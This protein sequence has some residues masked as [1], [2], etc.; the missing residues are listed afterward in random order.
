MSVTMEPKIADADGFRARRRAL[1]ILIVAVTIVAFGV[2]TL[3]IA[4]GGRPDPLDLRASAPLLGNG[5]RFHVGDDPRWAAADFDDSGW[6][7][8]DLSAP[9]S[10]NDGD[11]GLPNYTRGWWARGH[12]GHTGYGWYRRRVEVSAGARSWDI[13]GPTA[14]EDGYELYWN[15][16]RLG[17]SGRLDPPQRMV[18]T[19]PMIFPLPEDAAGHSGVLAIR[20]YMLPAGGGSNSGGIHVAPTLAPRP[21]SVALFHVEWWRTIAGY[22]VEVVEPL[23]MLGVIVLALAT[24]RHSMRPAFTWMICVALAFSGMRRLENAIVSWTDLMSLTTYVWMAGVLA[25]LILAAWAFAW[26]RWCSKPLRVIDAA[27]VVLLGIA[28]AGIAMKVDKIESACR[29]A[30]LLLFAV[31]AFRIIR[32]SPMR[33]K[34]FVTMALILAAQFPGE[35]SRLGVPGI[36]FPFGIGVTLA[37]YAYGLAIPMLALLVVG[38]LRPEAPSESV[39]ETKSGRS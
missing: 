4:I 21:H 12:A 30:F 11:V 27:A 32:G 2:T 15:G 9:A 6:E 3:V 13:V 22:I 26:N 23:A 38:T 25:P 1:A 28:L 33:I 29:Q 8:M 16:A 24:W 17:G 34:A 14:V 18:G 7:Q 20:T 35:L 10:S 39:L 37:Q 31:I 19:R 5:W 36:W